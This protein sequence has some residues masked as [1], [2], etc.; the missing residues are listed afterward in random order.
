MGTVTPGN[1]MCLP[2]TP[3]IML[4]AP[5]N[6]LMEF[7]WSTCVAISIGMAWQQWIMGLSGNLIY[8]M[9][10]VFPGPFGPPMPSIPLPLMMFS[11]SGESQFSPN[12]LK[13]SMMNNLNTFQSVLKAVGVMSNSIHA[14]AFFGAV[15]EAFFAVFQMYKAMTLVMP[16]F[17]MGP[18]P[19]FA[20]PFVPV[21]PVVG[22]TTLPIPVPFLTIPIGQI[23]GPTGEYDIILSPFMA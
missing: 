2:L 23:P 18:I 4:F 14:P 11:S 22:G 10:A 8:P 9:F 5:K 19:S 20:P 21:G 13:S 12:T 6:T 1:V 7:V 17:G 16:V 3:L 15:S